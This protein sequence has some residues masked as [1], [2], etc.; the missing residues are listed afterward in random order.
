MSQ[1]ARWTKKW[2]KQEKQA[3]KFYTQISSTNDSAKKYLFSDKKH[4]S[5]LFI[6]E[7][8]T[9]GRGRRN[10]RWINS[11]MMLSWSYPL[12]KAPEPKTTVLMGKALC[13]ALKKSWGA[14][15]FAQKKPNDIYIKKKK[16]AGI[17]IEVVSKGNLHQLVVG[18][19]MNVFP[20]FDTT[21]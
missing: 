16:L 20:D 12:N 13:T 1:I 10:R 5:F 19:G 17:L 9:K 11:D 18:A 3:F 4:N 15:A 7:S 6:T 2:A 14:C 8:Q 21:L